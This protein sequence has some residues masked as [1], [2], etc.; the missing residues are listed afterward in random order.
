MSSFNGV[1]FLLFRSGC[2]FSFF[3]LPIFSDLN[4]WYNIE[5][6]RADITVFFLILSI[7]RISFSVSCKVGLLATHSR[8]FV[9][10]VKSSFLKASFAEYRILRWWVFFVFVFSLQMCYPTACW[11]HCFLWEVSSYITLLQFP[12]KWYVVF[13]LL[14]KIFFL[15]LN[16]SIFTDIYLFMIFVFILFVICWAS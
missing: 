11:L 2:F 1:E 14:C 10:L 7:H 15:S 5:V 16:F 3:L 4:L 8:R 9:Y 13:L 12:C 6:S